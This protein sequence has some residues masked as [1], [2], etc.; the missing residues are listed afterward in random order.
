MGAPGAV[1]IHY[2]VWKLSST[3]CKFQFIHSLR[4]K[5]HDIIMSANIGEIVDGMTLIFSKMTFLNSSFALQLFLCVS[6][7]SSSFVLRP[8]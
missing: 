3:I 4:N 6:S 7:L 2:F 8:H 1:N 5:T